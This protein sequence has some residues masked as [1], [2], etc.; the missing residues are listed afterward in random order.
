MLYAENLC[1][2]TKGRSIFNV[3]F[4]YLRS[5]NIPAS[6]IIACATDGAPSMVGR[7]NGFITF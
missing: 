6:N 3:I 2:D 5:H 1:I 4:N 7:Y